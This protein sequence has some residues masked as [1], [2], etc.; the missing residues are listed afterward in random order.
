ML[1]L[2]GQFY[3]GS[4]K[5]VNSGLSL[6]TL[7]GM[8]DSLG[9]GRSLVCSQIY[10]LAKTHYEDHQFVMISFDRFLTETVNYIMGMN[11]GWILTD[12][13]LACFPKSIF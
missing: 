2:W 11:D 12:S 5:D 10:A 3:T 4:F 8:P 13:S 6:T 9:L 1:N 7:P